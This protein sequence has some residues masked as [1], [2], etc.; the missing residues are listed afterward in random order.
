VI[1]F[2]NQSDA[3]LANVP[4]SMRDRR[5]NELRE[6]LSSLGI[7]LVGGNESAIALNLRNLA[8]R[9]GSLSRGQANLYATLCELRAERIDCEPADIGYL[10]GHDVFSV[11]ISRGLESGNPAIVRLLTSIQPDELFTNLREAEGVLVNDKFTGDTPDSR[12]VQEQLNA[13]A[14]A[15]LVAHGLLPDAGN[16]YDVLQPPA[17]HTM[18]QMPSWYTD[19][20]A[21]AW[22]SPFDFDG[23]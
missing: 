10:T 12:W 17:E 1:A 22:K 3:P 13:G 19:N 11:G 18:P 7:E 14:R 20:N 2:I 23:V 9:S 4:P 8:T 6:Q 21:T 5:F 16:P 15:D